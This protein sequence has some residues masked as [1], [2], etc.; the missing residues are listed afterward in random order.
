VFKNLYRDYTSAAQAAVIRNILN[1][2]KISLRFYCFVG[3]NAT[4]NNSTL[5]NSLNLYLN[6]NIM[7]DNRMRCIG[8]IINLVV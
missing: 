1:A 3:D 5:I 6:I 2:Y 7:S 8:Y 4:S